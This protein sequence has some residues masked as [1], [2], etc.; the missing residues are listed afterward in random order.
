MK[1]KLL[2]ARWNT[3]FSIQISMFLLLVGM[4]LSN[5]STAN[6]RALPS[7][8]DINNDGIHIEDVVSYINE[9]PTVP[10]DVVWDLLDQIQRVA[11]PYLQVNFPASHNIVKGNVIRAQSNKDG[12]LYLIPW[13]SKIPDINLSMLNE[14]AAN[15]G[16]IVNNVLANQEVV[17]STTNLKYHEYYQYGLFAVDG[18]GNISEPIPFYVNNSSSRE[19]LNPPLSIVPLFQP[20]MNNNVFGKSNYENTTV[21]AEKFAVTLQKNS[22]AEETIYNDYVAGD[23]VIA[24]FDSTNEDLVAPA[25]PLTEADII[26]LSKD[27]LTIRLDASGYH[28]LEL[29]DEEYQV[30]SWVQSELFNDGCGGECERAGTISDST[31]TAL[32]ITVRLD[33]INSVIAANSGLA[34]PTW[35]DLNPE[36]FNLANI[37][38]TGSNLPAIENALLVF[39]N[40]KKALNSGI[41]S[42]LTYDEIQR[43]VNGVNP[44]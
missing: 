37:N 40:E 39:Y 18:L 7:I 19:R 5:Y 15:G 3:R 24:Y 11:V 2:N 21:G 14:G 41:G 9:T 43:V 29:Q 4:I 34:T 1:N 36:W 26:K 28:S 44:L 12:V 31:E 33:Q 10:H 17:L 35:T 27:D 23:T 22:G 32:K 13:V 42:D 20:A 38:N 16:L 6:A 25:Y 8:T 30:Y